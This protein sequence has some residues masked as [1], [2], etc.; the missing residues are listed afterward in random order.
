MGRCYKYVVAR[1]EANRVRGER[2]NIGIIAVR[3]DG[4]DV[5]IP[6]SLDKLKAISAALDLQAVRDALQQLP[7]IYAYIL[8]QGFDEANRMSAL[9]EFSPIEFSPVAEFSAGNSEQYERCLDRLLLTLVEPEPAPV[10]E[11]KRRHTKLLN[12]V[13][14]AFRAERV[15]ARQGEGLDAHRIVTNHKIAEGLPADLILKNGS[16][17]IVQ[18]VDASSVEA[19]VRMINSIAKSALVF[20]QARMQFGQ[21]GTN[22]KLVYKASSSLESFITP[23]LDAAQHQGASLV[24][25]ESREDRTRFI[26][27]ISSLAEP[28]ADIGR[29]AEKL[30]HASVQPKFKLN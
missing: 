21:K 3:E 6:K 13:K 5:R 28:L 20:E 30:L 2:L 24:N 9:A 29:K 19:S 27:E 12:D 4:I 18:T 17:H 15:M 11:V 1:F 26:V 8:S 25:W 22:A 16:M 14:S 23:S 10:Q 7:E